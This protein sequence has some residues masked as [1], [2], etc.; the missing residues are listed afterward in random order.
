MPS[1]L[2][3]GQSL[4]ILGC[5]LCDIGG[6]G[7]GLDHPKLVQRMRLVP[8][9]LELSGQGERLAGVLPGRLATARETTD[10]TEPDDQA[11]MILPRLRA[12]TFADPLFDQRTPL[13]ETSL[14][15]IAI[16]QACGDR[17]QPSPVPRGTTEG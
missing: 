10:L 15:R 3:P 5:G 6:V 7:V 1:V 9:F 11:G 12:E 4:L 8:T 13:R 17:P 16:A 14:E 2:G